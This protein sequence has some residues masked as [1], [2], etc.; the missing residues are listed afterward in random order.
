MSF[1]NE[2]GKYSCVDLKQVG[3]EGQKKLL[4]AKVLV[5][6]AG[7]LG[8]P[9]AMALAAAGVGTIGL[10]DGDT[11][12]L[13][14]LQRQINCLTKADGRAKKLSAQAIP[15]VNVV[16]YREIVEAD[17]ILSIFDDQNYDFIID[18]TNSFPPEFLI[19]DICVLAKKPVSHAI[20]L[21][22]I[23]QTMTYLPDKGPCYRCVCKNQPTTDP[24]PLCQ[25]P[26]LLDAAAEVMGTIQANEAI[27][28]ILDDRELLNG[29]L[30]KYDA[31][32]TNFHEIK[33]AERY[34]C[35][36]CGPTPSMGK[37]LEYLR[38]LQADGGRGSLWIT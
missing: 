10:V 18:G 27:K 23:G 29:Y 32:S 7:R 37:L 21:Q 3:V 31:V 11:E 20:I 36:V 33:L 24:I 15:D 17:N 12:K 38:V 34:K 22:F 16:T 25:D 13:S 19:S 9:A 6:G 8:V 30:L 28:Y 1:T 5:I 2:L 35:D 4:E 26:K 14:N